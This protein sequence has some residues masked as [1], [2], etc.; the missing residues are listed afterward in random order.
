MLKTEGETF[1]NFFPFLSIKE[2]TKQFNS[3]LFHHNALEF[4]Q[5]GTV[6]DT[7]NGH[8]SLL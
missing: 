6:K 2:G 3:S 5:L 1:A 8:L 4:T 7:K